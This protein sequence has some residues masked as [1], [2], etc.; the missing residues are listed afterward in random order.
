MSQKNFSAT[1]KV[2]PCRMYFANHHEPKAV[3]GRYAKHSS[4]RLVPTSAASTMRTHQTGIEGTQM[5]EK[6]AT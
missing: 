6:T 2:I 1:K 3:N 4:S 5:A